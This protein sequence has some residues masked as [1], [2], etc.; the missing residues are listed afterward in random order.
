MDKSIEEAIPQDILLTQGIV[1][2][3]TYSYH[4]SGVEGLPD[5]MQV[6]VSDGMVT[7][8]CKIIKHKRRFKGI[9]VNKNA[10]H[11]ECHKHTLR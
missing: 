5:C 6:G 2:G 1:Q 7:G 8:G 10:E 4:Y 3:K 11:D 9:G